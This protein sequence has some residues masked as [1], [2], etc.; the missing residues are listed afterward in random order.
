MLAGSG[1]A[2]REVVVDGVT[3]RTVDPTDPEDLLR[4]ILD[5]SGEQAGRMG[6]AGRDRF[7]AHFRYER[8]LERFSEQV[9]QVMSRSG[10]IAQ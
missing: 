10:A 6:R 2:G 7:T 9:Y 1:D 3:G 4:G 5:V 8:F